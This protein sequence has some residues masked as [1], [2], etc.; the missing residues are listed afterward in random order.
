MITVNAIVDR[1]GRY[2]RRGASHTLT[3]TTTFKDR[4]VRVADEW[5]L[6]SREQIGRP[7]VS[8]DKPE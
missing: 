6:K 2:G 5:K 3:D 7:S 4:W 8:V 1:E